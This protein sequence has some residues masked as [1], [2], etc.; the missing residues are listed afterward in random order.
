MMKKL[1]SVQFSKARDYLLVSARPL[2][3]SMFKFEFENWSANHV[4]K[5]LAAFQNADGGFGHAMEPD[6]RLPDSS[7]L[8]TTV[9]LQY[10]SKLQLS[11]TPSMVSRALLYLLRTFDQEKQ[12][13]EIVPKSVANFPRAEW[14]EWR[15]PQESER[16][17]GNPNAE[18]AGYLHEWPESESA[19]LRKAVTAKSFEKLREHTESLEMHELLCYL[20]LA[21]KLPQRKQREL[22]TLLESHVRA[23]VVVISNQWQAY[24]LRPLQVCPSPE[25]HYY[26]AFKSAINKNL[27]FLIESQGPEGTWDP[28]WQ[29]G[30]Y[31]VDW[32]RAKEEWKG[33]ITLE[34]LRFLRAYHRIDEG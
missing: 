4:L 5:E 22:Y 29:W 31:K 1:S 19:D 9:A 30:K 13:W 8:A 24:G 23:N 33:F 18:I 32:Q 25:S 12:L 21:G 11:K 14:W 34:N 7:A 10:I 26:P 20:R 3:R 27:D 28:T 6:F 16:F 17:W 15:D 2:D